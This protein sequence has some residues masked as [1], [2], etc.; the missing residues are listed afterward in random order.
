MP[1]RPNYQA[2]L[3][4][5]IAKY[6]RGNF[7]EDALDPSMQMCVPGFLSGLHA[8]ASTAGWKEGRTSLQLGRTPFSFNCL[9]S[10]RPL[11]LPTAMSLSPLAPPSFVTTRDSRQPA[12]GCL[13]GGKRFPL[14]ST[15]TD[16]WPW[17]TLPRGGSSTLHCSQGQGGDGNGR[18]ETRV[19]LV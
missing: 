5:Q 12:L 18:R 15:G 7:V 19:F 14:D 3:I 16:S 9:W 2:A 6:T 8:Q 10:S 11:H 4:A 13:L 17:D 1:R